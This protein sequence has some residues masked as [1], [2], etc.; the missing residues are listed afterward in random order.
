MAKYNVG[1]KIMSLKAI[2]MVLKQ[3]K[4]NNNTIIKTMILKSTAFRCSYIM[5]S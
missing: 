5:S 4:H 3:T 2:T 1:L